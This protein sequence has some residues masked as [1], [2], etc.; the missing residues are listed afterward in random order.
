M[1][2][3]ERAHTLNMSSN[4]RL[5]ES[6]ARPGSHQQLPSLSS[7]FGPPSAVC[8]LHLPHFERPGTYPLTSLLDHSRH[9][10]GGPRNSCNPQIPTSPSILQPQSTYHAQFDQRDHPLQPLGSFDRPSSPRSHDTV[11]NSS[12]PRSE[13]DSGGKWP[14]RHYFYRHWYALGS[15]DTGY[16]FPPDHSRLQFPGPGDRR[17]GH[18]ENRPAKSEIDTVPTSAST[19]ASDGVPSRDDLGPKIW[20]GTHFR[21]RFV[22]TAEVPGEGICHFYDDGSHCKIVIDGK[23]VNAHLGV[24]SVGKP[25]KR[26]PIACIKCRTKKTKCHLDYPRCAR[27]EKLGLICEFKNV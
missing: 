24:T 10:L 9:S 5:T 19:V 26:V 20:V 2:S 1:P 23:A 21:P 22:R 11:L 8:P 12:S 27:C 16:L 15:R 17:L 4:E 14:M 18:E 3:Y 7:L 25:R 13:T 6:N